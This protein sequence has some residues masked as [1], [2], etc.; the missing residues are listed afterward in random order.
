VSRSKQKSEDRK[1]NRRRDEWRNPRRYAKPMSKIEDIAETEEVRQPDDRAHDHCDSAND[2]GLVGSW[3]RRQVELC[4]S[5]QA[6]P[7]LL[8]CATSE[9]RRRMPTGR[10][11][12]SGPSTSTKEFGLCHV[13]PTA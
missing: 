11:A 1:V 3:S 8:T 4:G 12:T 9:G 5:H 7:G 6:S 13:R 2:R 10:I